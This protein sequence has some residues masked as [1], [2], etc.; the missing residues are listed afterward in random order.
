MAIGGCGLHVD[1]EREA[2]VRV[3]QTGLSGLEINREGA[4][5]GVPPGSTA[6]VWL[7]IDGAAV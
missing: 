1:A 4:C 7:P 6:S 3:S 2:R 5:A